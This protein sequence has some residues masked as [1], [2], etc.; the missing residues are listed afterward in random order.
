[1]QTSKIS[2][3][4]SVTI[5]VV[6]YNGLNYLEKTFSAIFQID[7][8]D[9]DVM[10]IDN[11]STDDSV[12]YVQKHFKA[13]TVH[14]MVDNRGPNIARNFALKNAKSRYLLL[15]D[16]DAIITKECLSNLIGVLTESSDAATCSPLI[17]DSKD[18]K[19][20][21]YGVTHIHFVGAALMENL[22]GSIS[23]GSERLSIATTINGT[24]LLVDRYRANKVG[25]FDEQMFFGWT[26]GDYSFRL[27]AAGYKCLIDNESKIL[28]PAS[29]RSK[30]IFLHQVKNR[31]VFILKNYSLKTILLSLPALIFY[32]ITFLPFVVFKGNLKEYFMAISAMIRELPKT[33]EKRKEFFKRKKLPDK[34]LLRSGDFSSSQSS[35]TNK[36]FKMGTV[37]V[38]TIL[39]KYWILIKRF[40]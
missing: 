1:M 28:H 8:P 31:W 27:T 30:K 18:E 19:R 29:V 15:L 9:Y 36:Y 5:G 38:N 23:E 7:Y 17:V 37:L 11:A 22:N 2:K 3:L 25:L 4:P 16:N 24:A 20:V 33:L 32:E 21:Q 12:E 40:I 35:I 13:V 39:D 14:E 34:K 10:L 6:N 26:D